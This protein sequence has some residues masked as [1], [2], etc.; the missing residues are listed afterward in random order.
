[1]PKPCLY[2][3]MRICLSNFPEDVGVEQVLHA[4]SSPSASSKASRPAPL[5]A[6]LAVVRR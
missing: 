1:V 6:R 2:V 4:C 5:S 3:L